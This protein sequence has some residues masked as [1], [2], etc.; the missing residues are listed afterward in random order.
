[1]AKKKAAKKTASEEASPRRRYVNQSD[2]P[3][4]SLREA[5][6]IAQ[7]IT[8]NFASDP[9]SPH[10]V[11][12][13]LDVSPTSSAWRYLSGAA[14]AYGLTKG[15]DQADKIVLTELGVHCTAPTEEG[16]D[17]AARAQAALTPKVPKR[18]FQK[19]NRKKFPGDKI[20]KNVLQQEFDVP[21]GRLDDTLKLLKDDGS[22]VGFIHQT[23][24]G[25]FV[26]IDNL[27]PS[28]V[29]V[30]SGADKNSQ[31]DTGLPDQ[32]IDD[33]EVPKS[34]SPPAG[35]HTPFRVFISHGK[36]KKIVDQVKDVLGLYDIDYEIAVEEESPAIPVPQKVLAAMRKCGAGI[37]I[38][39]PD[40]DEAAAAG[41]I[42]NNVLI[43]IGSAFVLYDQR[44]VLLWDKRLKVPSNLQGLYR[45]DFEG[46]ELSFASGTK[47]A[48]S[49]KGFRK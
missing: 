27:S 37:M 48:K 32:P 42:N 2:I 49:V 6:T 44:V 38:V 36:N 7:A 35:A 30:N 34:D 47:L 14:V 5:L 13:A 17:I 31:D 1:M 33:P 25:S 46:S 10:Q 20:A 11:A 40:N 29:T 23:K 16:D 24:T 45:C 4:H 9:T 21:A 28:P 15:G 18:F 12:M 26:S 3:R 19:Y 39:S 22:F 43:E 8:D 41:V